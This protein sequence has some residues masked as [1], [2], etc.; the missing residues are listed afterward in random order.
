MSTDLAIEQEMMSSV[1]KTGG[2]P[3]ERGMTELQHA[4]SLLPTPVC[5]EIKQAIHSLSSKKVYS[6]LIPQ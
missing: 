1:K 6:K 4:K 5:A 3:R 2:L